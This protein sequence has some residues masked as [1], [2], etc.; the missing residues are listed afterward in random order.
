MKIKNLFENLV[1]KNRYNALSNEL[2]SY[3]ITSFE[4]KEKTIEIQEKYILVLEKLT[5]IKEE[6]KKLKK[7]LNIKKN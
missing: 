6:L 4:E 2:E 7:E 1:W 3:K 5:R